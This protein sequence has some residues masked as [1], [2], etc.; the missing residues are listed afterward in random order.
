MLRWMTGLLTL[1]FLLALPPLGCS[2]FNY[3]TQAIDGHWQILQQRRSIAEI[4][5]DQAT[6]PALRQRLQQVEQL[7][8]F[9][10]QRLSLP[11]NDS[12]R[13]YADVQRAHVVYNVFAASE[14]SLRAKQWCFPLIGCVSYRGYYDRARAQAYADQLHQQG[15]DVYIGGVPAYSTLGW[16]A[17]PLLN[18]FIHWPLGQL[19]E[20]IF[21]ELAHQRLYIEGDTV[22]NESFA[23][24][25]GQL[26]AQLWLRDRPQAQREYLHYRAYRRDFLALVLRT[27]QALEDLYYSSQSSAVKRQGKQRLLAQ[28]RTAYERLKTQQWDGYTGYDRWFHQDLNNAKFAALHAYTRYTPTFMALFEQSGND[29]Q[30]F[31]HA[32]TNLGHLPRAERHACLQNW[33]EYASTAASAA[34]ISVPAACGL[35]FKITRHD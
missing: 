18:T 14:L 3:Y 30:R 29:F 32:V 23:S 9:A 20:L 22:F 15:Y 28:L 26:G 21:H 10:S 27:K 5:A 35:R 24:A 17:D 33:S 13:S 11:D 4:L 19:A 31:Y 8:N 7:R 16:F 25:V 12:Y 2:Q 34:K 1:V 6:T